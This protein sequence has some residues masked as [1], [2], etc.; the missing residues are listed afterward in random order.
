MTLSCCTHSARALT[1]G[2]NH[3]ACITT[4]RVR[5][6]CS[7]MHAFNI[8]W[9]IERRS[10]Q[11][12]KWAGRRVEAAAAHLEALLE[13]LRHPQ[14]QRASSVMFILFLKLLCAY[15]RLWNNIKRSTGVHDR[16]RSPALIHTEYDK[17]RHRERTAQAARNANHISP[18]LSTPVR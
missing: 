4:K 3:D 10:I 11:V 12:V 8:Y 9:C 18:L 17:Q 2:A 13:V 1:A 15:N 6:S 16:A 14:P 7:T 5:N